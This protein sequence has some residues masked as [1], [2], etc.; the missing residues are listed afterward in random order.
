MHN[1]L[2]NIVLLAPG[3]YNFAYT[4]DAVEDCPSKTSRLKLEVHRA[5][6]PGIISKQIFMCP[7]DDFSSYT[8]MNLFDLIKEEDTN[9]VWI[10]ASETKLG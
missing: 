3:T 10:D 1:E 8:N 6:R 9:G 2:S 7:S 4:I 5:P